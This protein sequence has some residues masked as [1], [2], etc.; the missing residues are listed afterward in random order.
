M[1]RGYMNVRTGWIECTRK[2]QS[3]PGDAAERRE[4]LLFCKQNKLVDYSSFFVC[5]VLSALLSPLLANCLAD[6]LLFPYDPGVL[7]V[8]SASHAR[9]EWQ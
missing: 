4:R 6:A 1:R 5:P 3:N 9:H 2:R 8:L 7:F